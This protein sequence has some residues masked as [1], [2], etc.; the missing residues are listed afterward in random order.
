VTRKG[1]AQGPATS[2]DPYLSVVVTARNDDH[3]GNPLY[4]TQLFVDGLFAQCERF[5]IPAELVLVEWNPPS[6]RPRLADVIEWPAAR[7]WCDVRIV[8]VPS[9][10]HIRHEY[11][12]RLPLFQMIGKNVGIRRAR[13]QFVLATNIDILFS[14]PLMAFIGERRLREG[15]LYRVD[16]YD[17]PAD[18]ERD[19]PIDE[20]LEHCERSAIRINLR[21]G[22]LD[23]QN[24]KFY[25]IYP[26]WRFL[27]KFL[28]SRAG[29][30]FDR[31]PLAQAV[32]RRR[33]LR[34]GR[35]VPASLAPALGLLTFPFRLLLAAWRRLAAVVT[36]SVRE[37]QRVVPRARRRLRRGARVVARVLALP[38]RQL[39][40]APIA[41]PLRSVRRRVTSARHD[42]LRDKARIRLHTNASG[43][44]TLLS[45][46]DWNRVGGYAEFEL[47]SMHI[48]GL[49]LY[50]AHYRGIRER[51][52]R[53][54]VYHIEH[55]G[56]FRPEAEG[57][58][59]LGSQLAKRALPQISSEELVD[60][61]VEMYENQAP[62]PFNRD[63]WGL[64]EYELTETAAPRRAGA[65]PT[66]TEMATTTRGGTS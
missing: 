63:D 22:T 41:L 38:P 60:W 33:M 26:E 46:S 28:N 5:R 56:G 20:Q 65:A 48:D 11:S 43:D 45:K 6:D 21:G 13:G 62:K 29:S 59:S 24:H 52:L 34:I 18:L 17:V 58:E 23:L 50:Q 49:F 42:A 44:F 53:A 36:V 2:A 51:F 39:A 10:L 66:A 19:W 12:D 31:Q 4:R 25:W 35:H 30:R 1:P 8:E 47:Y 15:V 16:R 64:A 32:L 54:P 57:D 55:G 61:F 27:A 40:A 37:P 7:D 9:D 14:D 3:G